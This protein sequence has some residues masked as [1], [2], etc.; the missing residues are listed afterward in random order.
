[1]V[2]THAY[3]ECLSEGCDLREKLLAIGNYAVKRAEKIGADQVEAYAALSKSFNIHVENNAVKAASRESDGGCG[4]RSV[5]DN[6]IG[7]AYVT[8][9][10]EKDIEEAVER[11]VALA[12]AS[13]P[14]PDFVSLPS[15][16]QEYPNVRGLFDSETESITSEESAKIIL[17]SVD[18]ARDVLSGK[19]VA[20]EAQLN[21]SVSER[22]IVNSLGVSGSA[23]TSFAYLYIS[24]T[25]KHSGEQTSSYEYQISRAVGDLNPQDVGIASAQSAIRNL[26]AHTIDGGDMQIVLDPLAV[27]TIIGGGFSGAVNAEEVQ[28]GRS[29]ISDALG[30]QIASGSL[31]V[32]DNSLLSGG[33]GSRPFD[34]EGFPSTHTSVLESGVLKSLLHNSYTAHKDNVENTGNASRSSYSGLPSISTS[35]LIIEAGRGTQEE[36]IAEIDRGILCRR[37]GDRPNMATGDLSAM[38]MEGFYIENGEVKHALKNTLFGINMLDLLKRVSVVGEDTRVTVGAITPSILVESGKVTSG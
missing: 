29:Y 18:S 12:R 25:I 34:A 14:D 24:P 23:K 19:K 37:T 31:S 7:F 36:L 28:Y 8:T 32:A 5:I 17:T 26:G 11:S 1:M 21:L 13:V 3:G 9:L 35:N 16:G 27:S 6:A 22:A 38:V 4:V 33:I 10:R 15:A 30:E 20:V 2:L